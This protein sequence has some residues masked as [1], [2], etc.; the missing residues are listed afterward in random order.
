MMDPLF[1]SENRL[2]ILKGRAARC[3]CKYCGGRLEIR[4]IVFN[5][6]EEARVEIFC[7]D[8]DRIE[9]GVEPE[10]YEQAQYIVDEL[11]FGETAVGGEDEMARRMQVAKVCDI[12]AW[13]AKHWGIL[14]EEGFT[15]TIAPA[16]KLFPYGVILEDEDLL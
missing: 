5:S 9:Y 3:R 14:D 6:F 16:E 1:Y 13:G 11:R 7:A 4:Q 15:I 8:C 2:K 10:I 12:L